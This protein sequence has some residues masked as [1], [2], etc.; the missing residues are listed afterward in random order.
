MWPLVADFFIRHSIVNAVPG[1]GT[2]FLFKVE[3]KHEIKG[4]AHNYYSSMDKT[5][6]VDTREKVSWTWPTDSR[7]EKGRGKAREEPPTKRGSPVQ[8]TKRPRDQLIQN[9]CVWGKGSGS[10]RPGNERLRSGDRVRSTRRSHRYWVRLVLGEAK[11]RTQE[12]WSHIYK[13]QKPF[14]YVLCWT[15]VLTS[16]L[17]WTWFCEHLNLSKWAPVFSSFVCTPTSRTARSFS[18]STLNF[19]GTSKPPPSLANSVWRFHALGILANTCS[20]LS[21]ISW[22]RVYIE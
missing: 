18:N 7:E 15:S 21:F 3:W 5:F 11:I 22:T 12:W 9:C 2:C 8:E 20:C 16:W 19:L 4:G 13:M 1:M 10:P 6:I 17:L 14:F